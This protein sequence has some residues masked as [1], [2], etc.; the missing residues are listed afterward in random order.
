MTLT[1]RERTAALARKANAI[2]NAWLHERE[3]ALAIQRSA[4]SEIRRNWKESDDKV[5]PTSMR[6]PEGSRQ[7][8]D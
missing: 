8:Q 6:M 1:E 2:R 4:S 7:E 3:E 5:E